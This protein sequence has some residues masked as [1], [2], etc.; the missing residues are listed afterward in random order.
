MATIYELTEKWLKV[1][2]LA[3][4]GADEEAVANA[5]EDIGGEIEEKADG[6][7]RVIKSLE[8][9]AAAIKSETERLTARKATL[10]N[11]TKRLKKRL[12]EAMEACEK[13]KFKTL[14]FS[15]GIQKNAPSVRIE[16]ESGFLA[17]AQSNAPELVR[18]KTELD[19]K[20]ILEQLKAGAH[21]DGIELRQTASLRIR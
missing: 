1:K 18:T 17:W 10:E 14:L 21:F 6:Y 4:E 2:E 5:L 12:K 7:A 9:E 19:R 8:A 15:F 3:E 20:Q 11:S 16:D 13:T